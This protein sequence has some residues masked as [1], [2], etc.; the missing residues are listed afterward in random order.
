MPIL[1]TPPTL[2]GAAGAA[3]N[4][5]VALSPSAPFTQGGTTV[6]TLLQAGVVKNGAF[7][8]PDGVSPLVIPWTP[9]NI[10][11]EIVLY[12]EEISGPTSFSRE[13]GIARKVR[14]P[15]QSSVT[16]SQ[17]VDV[18]PAVDGPAY[19]VPP[20]AS[21]V[22]V[23]VDEAEAAADRAEAAALEAEEA[24]AGAGGATGAVRF[25]TAQTLTTGAKA[26]ARDN[27]GAVS[28]EDVAELAP[29]THTHTAEQISNATTVGRAV[30]KASTAAAARSAMNAVGS[31]TMTQIE[32]YSSVAALPATGAAGVL[33]VTPEA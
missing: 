27:I 13:R 19:V 8:G 28:A 6:Q 20:W 2:V 15:N 12:L 9:T 14:V 4:G 17:L 11:L 10:Y 25:D 18:V 29:A 24:A 16:W 33:Y 21:A 31:G 32:F 30:M 23:A 26:Q 3:V 5:R 22:L 1:T 7:Y